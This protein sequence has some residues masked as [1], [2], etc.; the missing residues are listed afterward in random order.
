MAVASSLGTWLLTSNS[1]GV[2]LECVAGTA[3]LY[4]PSGYVQANQ[5]RFAAV[6]GGPFATPTQITRWITAYNSS[7]QVIG[8]IPV[9]FPQ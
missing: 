9:F 6:S 4:I 2:K 5:Y 8:Q 7:G 1:T 3:G